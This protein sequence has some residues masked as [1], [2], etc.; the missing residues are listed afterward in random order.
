MVVQPE[1]ADDIRKVA[2][3]CHGFGAPGEDLVGLAQEL[4]QATQAEEQVQL[5]FPAAPLSLD[6]QGMPG[7]RAWW[8]LSISRLIAAMEEGRFEQ[9]RA[10]VP[11]GIDSA[12][13]LLTETIQTALERVK[14]T[15]NQLMLGGFSQGAML[16]VDVACRGLAKPPAALTL[17]SGA[18][19]CEKFWTQSVSNLAGC[20]IFQSH[21]KQDPILPFTMGMWLRDLLIKAGC[22]VDFLEFNGPHTIPWE[23]LQRSAQ[24]LDG[25]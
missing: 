14:L 9:V 1:V 11:E 21:G 12:R 15:E 6:D 18:L 25:V 7:G 22:D 4:L 23:A 3:L 19:I 8:L 24:L 16:A 13:E 2:V 17:Y 10:E 5:I 20:K